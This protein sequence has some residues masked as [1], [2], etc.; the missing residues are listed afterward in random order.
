MSR[1]RPR[2]WPRR[3]AAA[4]GDAGAAAAPAERRDGQAPLVLVD[5]RMA[6][7]RKTGIGTYIN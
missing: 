7:R 1:R 4:P 2:L 6:K 5:G 3:G